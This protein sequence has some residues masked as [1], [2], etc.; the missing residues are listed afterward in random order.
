L[1]DFVAWL[2]ADARAAD[3]ALD[4]GRDDQLHGEAE[5]AAWEFRGQ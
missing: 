5:L 4:E 3:Q 2:I 1:Y